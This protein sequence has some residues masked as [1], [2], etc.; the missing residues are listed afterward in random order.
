M[1]LLDVDVVAGS[2]QTEGTDRGCG[3]GPRIVCFMKTPLH[4]YFWTVPLHQDV[5]HVGVPSEG[6]GQA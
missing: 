2:D 6:K 4:G 1:A 3:P 5:K